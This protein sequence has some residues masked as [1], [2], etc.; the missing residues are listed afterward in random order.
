[1]L[2]IEISVKIIFKRKQMLQ[3]LMVLSQLTL[4]ANGPTRLTMM[5]LLFKH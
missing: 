2:V 5:I 1:M 3:V 4:M